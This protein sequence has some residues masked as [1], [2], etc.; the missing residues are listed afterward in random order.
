MTYDA[1]HNC[2]LVSSKE[3]A[4]IQKCLNHAAAGCYRKQVWKPLEKIKEAMTLLG[5]RINFTIN[6]EAHSNNGHHQGT[7]IPR[8]GEKVYFSEMIPTM[9]TDAVSG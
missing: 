8:D 4:E 1:E 9:K 7:T 5:L 6:L 2:F 3:L